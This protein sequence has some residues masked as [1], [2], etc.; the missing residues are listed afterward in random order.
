MACWSGRGMEQWG[1]HI[2]PT[3]PIFH[4][5]N[6]RMRIVSPSTN[7]FSETDSS[8]FEVLPEARPSEILQP[9]KEFD[10]TGTARSYQKRPTHS[11]LDPCPREVFQYR[12]SVSKSY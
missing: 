5:S 10:P 3:I 1:C 8:P 4:Y 11:R 2:K 9:E 6:V 12:P 7:R